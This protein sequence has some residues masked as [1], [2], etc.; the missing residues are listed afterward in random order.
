MPF[1]VR[2][3]G[4]VPAGTRTNALVSQADLLATCAEI[5]GATLPEDAGE[6][7]ISLLPL[8]GPEAPAAPVR[9]SIIHHS[10]EGRFA[11]R[12]GRWKLLAWPGSGGW[13][14]PT[15]HPSNWLDVPA[16]DLS[17]LPPFQLYDL[18]ADPAE[19]T[20]LAADHPDVVARLGGLLRAQVDA[21]RSTPGGRQPV[22]FSGWPQVEWRTKIPSAP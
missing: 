16:V 18:A 11:I 15:P 21:G 1:I 8:L 6:D 17:T 22:D 2:W 14:A 7:S 4:H 13:S 12:Q 9:D 20:N 10:G 19:R 3:P 5:V